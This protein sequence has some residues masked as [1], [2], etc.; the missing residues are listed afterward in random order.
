MEE[1]SALQILDVLS[2]EVEH[3]EPELEWEEARA[4]FLVSPDGEQIVWSATDIDGG[5]ADGPGDTTRCRVSVSQGDSS[6]V[7]MVVEQTYEDPYHLIPITWTPD[8]AVFLARMRVWVEGG[9]AFIPTFSE[10][11]SELFPLD[12]ASGAF[13]RVF[14]LGDTPVCNRCIGDVSP[15]GRWLAY[16]RADG[17]LVLRD[18]VNGEEALVA[19]ASSACY[20]GRARLS[21]DGRHLVCVEM[22][23]SCD[24]QDTFELARTVMVSVPF[25]RQPRVLAERDEAVD[26][27]V[28][29]LD[30]E[31]P[32][33]DRVYKGSD[34]PDYWIAGHSS[35]AEGLLPGDLIGVVRSAHGEREGSSYMKD[36]DPIAAAASAEGK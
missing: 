33:F 24:Q 31:T 20:L 9:G 3:V 34:Q 27:P 17:S 5:D 1:R 26:W 28:G 13:E 25:E 29:W 15:D 6:D 16:H 10:R 14:P 8:G 35:A 21:P 36:G 23:G 30:H 11:Y 18:L 32:I 12:L 2:A 4:D 7:R 19:D 22:E